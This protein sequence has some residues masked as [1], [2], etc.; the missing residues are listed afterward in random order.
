MMFGNVAPAPLS[1]TCAA[2]G[3]AAPSSAARA[4]NRVGFTGVFL[5]S[6]SKSEHKL[7]L[8]QHLI[9][10]R[11]AALERQAIEIREEP[12]VWGQLVR[13]A[14]DDSRVLVVRN[15]LIGIDEV[16]PRDYRDFAVRQVIDAEGTGDAPLLGRVLPSDVLTRER[17][18]LGPVRHLAEEPLAVIAG[19]GGAVLADPRVSREPEPADATGVVGGFDP[20]RDARFDILVEVAG[21]ARV[22]L[23][24]DDRDLAVYPFIVPMAVDAHTDVRRRHGAWS[25]DR[26]AIHGDG[27]L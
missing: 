16:D 3:T 24:V 14:T 5:W 10:G 13:H 17:Q 26:V 11:R 27:A 22:A 23:P 21:T 12:H 4:R 7:G 15:V 19:E 2:A 1:W 9:R 6:G 20:H 25:A 8:H 18:L